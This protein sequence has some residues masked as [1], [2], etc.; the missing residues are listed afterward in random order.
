[1]AKLWNDE[2]EYLRSEGF[3]PAQPAPRLEKHCLWAVRR[4]VLKAT[5]ADL[6]NDDR[7]TDLAGI[8]RAIKRVERLVKLEPV[9]FQRRR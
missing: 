2:A 8:S 7:G 9:D 1:M 5:L 6:S 3:R 4:R